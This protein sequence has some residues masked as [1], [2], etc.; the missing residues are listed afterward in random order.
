VV[1]D[2]CD[3]LKPASDFSATK[4]KKSWDTYNTDM[5]TSATALIAASKSNNAKDLTGA[6]TKLDGSCV[7]C[8]NMFK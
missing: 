2:F 7:A 3:T 8:H 5:K 4:P 6:F 1:A